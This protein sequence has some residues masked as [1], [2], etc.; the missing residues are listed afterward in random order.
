MSSFNPKIM[1]VIMKG[2]W[3]L[4]TASLLLPALLLAQPQ[5]SENFRIT[6]SVLDAGGGASNSTNFQLVSAFGQPTPIGVSSSSNFVLSAGFLSPQFAASPLSPIQDLVIRRAPASN[7]MQLDW[8]AIAGA[9]LYTIYRDTNPLF[10]PGPANQ[11][12]T[13]PTNSFTDVNAVTLP[14]VKH[15]YNVTSSSGSSPMATAPRDGSVRPGRT[16]SANISAHPL[17]PAPRSETK[18]SSPSK[19]H[20][21]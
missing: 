1:E 13:S 9:T 6:K 20:L 18:E 21:R 7:N 12:G 16:G 15:F 19:S 14:A 3:I 11:L 17:P 2:M 5:Q 10:T 8:G 4:R